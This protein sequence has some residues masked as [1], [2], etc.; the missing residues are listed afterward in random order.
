MFLITFGFSSQDS[1]ESSNISKKTTEILVQNNKKI[2]SLEEKERIQT[3]E[4]LETVIRKIAHFSLY[5]IIG[6]LLIFL[7]LTF[8]IKLK[9]KI[10]QSLFIGIIYA[11][12]DEFHQIFSPGRSAELG[13][14]LIDTSG[15]L[16]GIVLG[17]V[18]TKIVS[19]ILGK[20]L[21]KQ[22]KTYY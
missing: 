5:A 15:V 8:D 1:N 13:D 12:T 18:L 17:I 10:I 11:I 3:I 20:I 21:K 2:Q 9:R 19:E 16:F 7:N 6:I 22:C 14:I 4:E